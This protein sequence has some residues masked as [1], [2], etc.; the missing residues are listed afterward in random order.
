MCRDE[1][2]HCDGE[3]T[4]DGVRAGVGSDGIAGLEGGEEPRGDDGT[5]NA[6]V[7]GAPIGGGQSAYH[8]GRDK[9]SIGKRRRF[10]G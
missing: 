9:L 4:V 5:A 1:G 10:C 6:W 3:G 8:V 7:G 2:A